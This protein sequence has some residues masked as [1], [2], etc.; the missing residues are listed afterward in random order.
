MRYRYQKTI[1]NITFSYHIKKRDAAY[2]LVITETLEENRRHCT[3]KKIAASQSDARRVARFFCENAVSP[4]HA[5]DIFSE[6]FG[7][8]AISR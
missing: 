3:L 6:Y 5:E 1:E 4:E 7:F 8:L 2:D